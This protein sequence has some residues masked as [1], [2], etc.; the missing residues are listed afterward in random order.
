MLPYRQKGIKG[1]DGIKVANQRSLSGE[2]ILDYPGEF[3]VI[4]QVLEKC[5]REAEASQR[6][7]P[8]GKTGLS[9]ATLLAL[10]MEEEGR[11]SKK[12]G[13]LWKLVLTP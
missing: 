4:A 3:T 13:G 7:K 11:E 1:I 9:Y 12:G 10:K 5:K 6:E 2:M 8:L